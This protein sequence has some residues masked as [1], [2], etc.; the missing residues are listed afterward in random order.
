VQLDADGQ[1]DPADAEVPGRGAP[2]AGGSSWAGRIFGPDSPRARRYG[3]RLSQAFVWAVTGSFAIEDPLCGFRCFRCGV[4]VPLLDAVSLGDRM[5]FDLEIVVR[6]AWDGVPIV[7]VPTRVRF[8]GGLSN[9]GSSGTTRS[10]GPTRGSCSRDF[11]DGAGSSPVTPTTTAPGTGSWVSVAE[12]GSILGMRFVVW[13]YRVLGRRF[14]QALILPVVLYFFLTDRK[15]RRAS[16]QYLRR[17][18]AR[19]GGPEALGGRP[20]WRHALRHYHAYGLSIL[21]RVGFWL[22]RND[23][24]IVSTEEHDAVQQEGRGAILLGTHLGS[25]DALRPGPPRPGGRERRDVHPACA[26]D[27]LDPLHPRPARRSG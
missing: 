19:P 15:G 6:L 23:D 3:R 18:Y 14:C 8:T 7:N 24:T 17:L 20:T 25:F 13:C 2:A 12:R 21:D 26:D 5:E 10:S 4:T 9:S 16:L 27:Q 1:H 11:L 22:G